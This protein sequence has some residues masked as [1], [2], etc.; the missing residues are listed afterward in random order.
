MD[1]VQVLN[2]RLREALAEIAT[3][4]RAQG[5]MQA[6]SKGAAQQYEQNNRRGAGGTNF[7]G[8]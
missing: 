2:V 6:E 7:T 8:D 4:N 1:V 5:R 3:A